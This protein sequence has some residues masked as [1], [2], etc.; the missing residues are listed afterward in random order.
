MGGINDPVEPVDAHLVDFVFG[1]ILMAP[2]MDA[3]MRIANFRCALWGYD[4]RI[5]N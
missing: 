5:L 2:K 4:T 3:A 1:D